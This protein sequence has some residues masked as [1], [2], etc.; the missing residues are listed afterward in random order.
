MLKLLLA[1]FV[2]FFLV[3]LATAILTLLS[4]PDIGGSREQ[5]IAG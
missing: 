2:F 5:P 3:E 1:L 4:R